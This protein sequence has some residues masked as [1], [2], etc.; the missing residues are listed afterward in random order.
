VAPDPATARAA[1]TGAE[2]S[3]R[4]LVAASS[5]VAADGG[6]PAM[7]PVMVPSGTSGAAG[8]ADERGDDPDHRP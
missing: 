1:E 7:A 2:L 8:D 4:G 6:E 3:L 5:L